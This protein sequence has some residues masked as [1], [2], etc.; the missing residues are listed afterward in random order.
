MAGFNLTAADA[1]LKDDYQGPIRDQIN[2]A[3]PFGAQITRKSENIVGRRAIVPLHVNRSEA[4]GARADGG[5]LPTANSQGY[6]DAIIGLANNYGSIRVTGPT[7]KATAS[8]S[9][10]FLK[11]VDSETKTMG[12]E[13]K[14]DFARQLTRNDASGAGVLATLATNAS[15]TTLNL[16]GADSGTALILRKGQKVDFSTAS[17]INTT[18]DTISSVTLTNGVPTAIVVG[19][20]AA[21]TSGD[22]ITRTGNYGNELIGI[23]GIVSATGTLHSVDPATYPVW[24]STSV[25]NGGSSQPLSEPLMLQVESGIEIASGEDITHLLLQQTQRDK[26]YTLLS[27]QKRAVNKTELKGGFSALTWND[28]TPLL[29]D[30]FVDPTAIYFLNLDHLALEQMCDWEWADE[31]GAILSRATDNTDSFTAYMRNISQFSTDM[32]N[33]HGILADLAV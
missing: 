26:F 1:I 7:M 9:G 16:T 29:V 25:A 6:F 17:V 4:V 24:K 11:A 13:T 14:E 30:R 32:R 28:D 31:D 12:K 23:K 22:V 2:Y 8:D 21:T 3:T 10:A 18:A 19:T 27:S 20:A 33:A 15:G 5:T